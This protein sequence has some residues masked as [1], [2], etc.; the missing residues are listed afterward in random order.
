VGRWG[1]LPCVA[2]DT[3]INKEAKE[4]TAGSNERSQPAQ[5]LIVT[6]GSRGI[7]A[8]VA[9]LA[10]QRGYTVVVNYARDAAGAQ[11]VVDEIRAAGGQAS[12]VQADVAQEAD[13]MRLFA[14]ADKLGSLAGL[15]NNGGIAGGLSRVDSLSAQTL[16]TVLAVN[17]EGPFLCSREAV[18]R[19]ST[20]HGG[21]G[22][23][24]VNMSSQ[25]ARIGGGGEW[26]HYA[27][28]K[29]AVDTLTI[30]LAR[31]VADEGIRVN[32]VSPGLIDT[33]I[34]AA[35]GAADRLTRLAPGVPMKRAGTADEV[36]ESV[37]WLLSPASSYVT[38]AIVPVSGG[39]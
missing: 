20:R 17:V 8:A 14:E 30:G 36:A 21:T 38:G 33:E 26:V 23:A 4:M 5:V 25:A 39:R 29:A 27:A 1:D 32:A 3:D 7:G 19:L 6:G 10:A 22:G 12:S 13:V 28:S 34:H 31:E 18:K 2:L 37:L 11:G 15:V 9:R 24:I 35:N 16:K